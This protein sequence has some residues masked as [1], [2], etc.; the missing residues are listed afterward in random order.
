M[1]EAGPGLS[2]RTYWLVGASEGLGRALAAEL[3]AAGAQLI[4]S[5]RNADKLKALAGDLPG[6]RAL[7]VD[8][9]DAASVTAA[10]E[11]AGPVDGLIYCAGAYDPVTATNWD[12]AA[13]ERMCEVNFTGGARVLGHVVPGMVARGAG[14]VVLIGSLA[15]HGGLPGAIGY[16]SSKAG[17]MHLAECLYMDLRHKGIKVQVVNPGFIR[18]RLTDKNDF[19]MPMIMSPEAAARR[20][21]RA[22]G[23]RRFATSF[24]APFSWLFLFARLLPVPWAARLFPARD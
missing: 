6:T 1:P 10:A 24:P 8:V 2:G 15:G 3:H 23:S 5:A 13:V 18:T 14:H 12:A 20:V 16:G 21:R 9:T 7:A 22:M 4:L 11:A 17:L 19:D